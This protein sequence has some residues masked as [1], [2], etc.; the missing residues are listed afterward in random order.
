MMYFI[1]RI[2]TWWS[3]AN[4]KCKLLQDFVKQF[5]NT[6]IA[7]EISRDALVEDI[8]RKVEELNQA[9]PRTKPLVV[10][11]DICHRDYVSCQPELRKIEDLYDFT[12]T[13]HIPPVRRTYRFSEKAA[14]S[15]LKE[16]GDK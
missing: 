12:F 13:F 5:E 10:D 15:L 7:D 9:Y 8:R 1:Q 14:A 3:P 6:L 16:G 2:N 4:Q 11:F